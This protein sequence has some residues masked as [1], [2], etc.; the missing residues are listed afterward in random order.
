MFLL[1]KV[2][3]KFNAITIKIPMAF[4]TELGKNPKMCMEL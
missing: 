3:Y 1:P 4:I 2:T